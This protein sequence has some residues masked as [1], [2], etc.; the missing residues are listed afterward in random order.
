MSSVSQHPFFSRQAFST[1]RPLVFAWIL[2]ATVVSSLFSSAAWSSSTELLSPPESSEW[3]RLAQES[4]FFLS[5]SAP[6]VNGGSN[7]PILSSLNLGNSA[8]L[9]KCRGWSFDIQDLP[10]EE[11]VSVG[12]N[13]PEP[14]PIAQRGQTR[15]VVLSY[16]YS[17]NPIYSIVTPFMVRQFSRRERSNFDAFY[18]GLTQA[19]RDRIQ[20]IYFLVFTSRNAVRNGDL[21]LARGAFSVIRNLCR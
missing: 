15:V 9:P 13:F 8:E 16:L 12:L 21:G 4:G 7:P 19:D 6:A 2:S 11:E 14:R 20:S 17:V 10:S 5:F 18:H 1:S 3:A